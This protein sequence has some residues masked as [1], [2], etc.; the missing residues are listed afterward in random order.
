M[1][2]AVGPIVGGTCVRKR[3]QARSVRCAWEG[4]S[5][6]FFAFCLAL[7][8]RSCTIASGTRDAMSRAATRSFSPRKI[9]RSSSC[10]STVVRPRASATC[11][12]C[13]AAL[14]TRVV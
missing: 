8:R 7:L 10:A 4:V 6:F 12:H 11:G 5:P 3:F 9:G 2:V 1:T 13:P 14:V